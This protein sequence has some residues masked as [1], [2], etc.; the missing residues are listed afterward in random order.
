MSKIKPKYYKEIYT[1]DNI[2]EELMSQM[3][4]GFVVKYGDDIVTGW[5]YSFSTTESSG[6]DYRG[7]A[8]SIG[9]KLTNVIMNLE[10]V[11][12]HH[13]TI[14]VVNTPLI[15]FPKEASAP[16]VEQS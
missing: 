6:D 2:P 13:S 1:K 9:I 12:Y 4:Y 5:C 10:E 11:Y 3:R 15:F 14:N 16:T 8:K 7:A